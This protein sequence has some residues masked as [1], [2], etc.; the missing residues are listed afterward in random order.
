MVQLQLDCRAVAWQLISVNINGQTSADIKVIKEK[1]LG[2]DHT[3]KRTLQSRPF[4]RPNPWMFLI[5]NSKR[6]CVIT[7]ANLGLQRCRRLNCSAH[8]RTICARASSSDTGASDR[9]GKSSS[10]GCG[11]ADTGTN[12]GA[13][14]IPVCAPSIFLIRLRH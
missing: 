14:R 3:H 11:G 12:C 13:G 5:W 2:F 1:L 9:E 10:S 6:S 8:R 7:V 4:K